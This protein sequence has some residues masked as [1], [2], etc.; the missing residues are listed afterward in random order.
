MCES[1]RKLG[2]A[3]VSSTKERRTNERIQ[4]KEDNRIDMVDQFP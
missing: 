1:L 2:Q 4:E 3:A